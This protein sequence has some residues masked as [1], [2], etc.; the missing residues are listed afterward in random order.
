MSR[1]NLDEMRGGADDGQD[2]GSDELQFG[3]RSTRRRT[4]YEHRGSS[5]LTP[6][7]VMDQQTHYGYA[8]MSLMQGIYVLQ[9]ILHHLAIYLRLRWLGNFTSSIRAKMLGIKDLVEK[10]LFFSRWILAHGEIALLFAEDLSVY[11]RRR[12]RFY[13]ANHRRIDDITEQ[14]CFTWFSQNH[15]NMR[16]LLIHLRVPDILTNQSNGAVYSGEECF[17]V[18]LYHMTKGSPF[19]EMAR[20]VFGGDPRRL[21]EMNDLYIHQVY[22]TFYNKISGTSLNQ[23]LPD[24]MNLCRELICDSVSSGAIEE[25]HMDDGQ[26]IDRQWILHRFEYASFR[27]F[28]FLDDFALPTARPGNSASR[29]EGFYDDIQRA[30]YSGYLRKH[31]LKAQVVFLP[32]GLIG[33]IFIT[34][35]RQNDNGVLNMSG[36]NDYLCWLLSGHLIRGLFPCL[37]CDGIFAI[38]STILPRYVNPTPEQIYMNLKF[39]SERQC[40]EHCFSDH[41]ARFKLFSVSHYFHLFDSGVKVR[42]QCLISFF[43]LNCYYC[44]D[45]TRSGYFGH[46]TP[47]LEEYLP[48]DEILLPPPAV[49]LGDTWDF[50]VQGPH[51]V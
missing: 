34:E 49:D 42:K 1:R 43:M 9:L 10:L 18:W 12:H 39:A 17:L 31:G 13:P 41:R 8:W 15:V 37:Y 14:D 19:T 21:S 22:N 28:G 5:S 45:G 40:I 44:L 38:H 33:S 23:W 35:L 6:A 24:K 25:I 7:Q 48:L 4:A 29:R 27:V 20:F 46:A 11:V 26:V 47:T 36:L 3:W 32:I 51:N 30:F 50:W 16:R 2:D